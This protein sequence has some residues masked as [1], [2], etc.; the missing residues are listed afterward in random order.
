MTLAVSGE[1]LSVVVIGRNEGQRL[2]GCLESARSVPG[3]SKIQ[4]IYVDSNSTDPSPQVA[5]ALGAEV[6]LLGPGR[7]TAAMGRNAGLAL[8]FYEWVLFLD[9]DTILNPAFPAAAAAELRADPTLAGVWGH[10]RETHPEESFYNRLLDLDWMFAPG[11][12][13]YC[14]GD[15]LMRRE[16][17][18]R[19]DGYD[20][21][22][23]AGEEPELCRRLR[24]EGYRILHI[25][26]AMTGHDL[27]ITHFW[28]YWRRALRAGYAYAEVSDRFRNTPAPLWLAESRANLRRGPFWMGLL[29]LS[30]AGAIGGVALG[31]SLAGLLPAALTLLL[32]LLLALRTARRAAWKAPRLPA[33]LFAYGVHSHLQQIPIFF[34]QLAFHRRK[35]HRESSLIEYKRPPGIPDPPEF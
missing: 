22:L 2:A 13:D 26:H 9:G 29:L 24:A 31:Y 6:V 17:I 3:F 33:L 35:P 27:Q 4:L 7:T 28:Q 21:S 12:V 14:G 18:L 19:V 20:A 10:R 15:V 8:A 1:G 11:Y 32:R 30:F 16:A 23:I 5:S 25:D 34:G